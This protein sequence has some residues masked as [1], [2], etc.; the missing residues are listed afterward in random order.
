MPS[1]TV[2]SSA[3]RDLIDHFAF[4][5]SHTGEEAARSFLRSA[6]ETFER[7]AQMPRVGASR[8]FRNP[9]FEGV[10]MW[11]V[12]GF[13]KHLIF[14]R[15]LSDGIVVLRVVHGARDLEALF[16]SSAGP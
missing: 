8:R 12:G 14:Y 1:V 10:R 15:A 16:D 7:L 3:Q 9:R 2:R 13:P 5:G 4:I 6:H 11:R